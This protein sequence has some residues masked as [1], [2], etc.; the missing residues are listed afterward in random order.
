MSIRRH[1]RRKRSRESSAQQQFNWDSF[2][3]KDE[4]SAAPL[5]AQIPASVF[6]GNGCGHGAESL[7]VEKHITIESGETGHSYE[8]LFGAYLPGAKEIVVEDPFVRRPYQLQNFLG[9]CELAVKA[10]SVT[11][12]ALIT[13]SDDEHQKSDAQE[14][15]QMMAA[16]LLDHGVKLSVMFEKGLHDREIR[17]DNGWNIKIGRGFDFHQKPDN[18]FVIGANYFEL[19]P[20]LKTK[21][22]IFRC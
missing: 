11:K 14:K 7:L 10:G 3:A 5:T 15:F 17:L 13:G 6:H 9:F 19:R 4:A 18:W 16:S 22:D 12:I 20:C 8:R 2:P 1:A 21:V